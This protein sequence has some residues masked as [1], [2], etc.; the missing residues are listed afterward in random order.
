MR[1]F[2]TEGGVHEVLNFVMGMRISLCR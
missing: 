1:G 2:V